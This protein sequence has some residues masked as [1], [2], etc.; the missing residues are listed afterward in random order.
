M[1]ALIVTFYIINMPLQVQYIT[2]YE[3]EQLCTSALMEQRK[4]MPTP[5]FDWYAATIKCEAEQ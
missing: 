1:T 3:T 4:N 5:P 2:R